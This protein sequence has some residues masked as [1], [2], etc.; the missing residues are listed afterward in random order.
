MKKSYLVATGLMLITTLFFGCEN[1]VKGKT[2]TGIGKVIEP[3]QILSKADAKAL[4]GVDV[5]E[6]V[7]KEQPKVGLK[8]CVYEKDK[9]FLQVGVT[10]TA[11][12]NEKF[13]RFGN[14]PETI[15]KTTKEA[16][17]NAERIDGV[18]DDNFLAPPGLHIMQNG[19]YLT[20]SFGVSND[21]EKLKAAGMTA[22]DNL[23]K[24]TAKK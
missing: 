6:G 19:Y 1:K 22:V 23:K 12:M 17:P 9:A 14:T 8:L 18:G 10:Q 4:T 11:F 7:V 5:G 24:Y 2:E 20:V 15:Y 13:R 3:S 21:R 16:F